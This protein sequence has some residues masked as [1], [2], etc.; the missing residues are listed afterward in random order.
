[1]F[2]GL[3]LRTTMD[4][5]DSTTTLR[6]GKRVGHDGDSSP[7][8][9]WGR[10]AS[11]LSALRPPSC[12]LARSPQQGASPRALLQRRQT[13]SV[14]LACFHNLHHIQPM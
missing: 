9:Q 2:L 3:P 4:T 12:T 1:M 11:A 8:A 7:A 10:R 14:V 5:T 13:G 6:F